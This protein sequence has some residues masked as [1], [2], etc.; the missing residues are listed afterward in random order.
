ALNGTAHNRSELITAQGVYTCREEAASVQNVVSQE[1]KDTAMKLVF[2]RFQREI[3][4]RRVPAVLGSEVVLLNLKFLYGLAGWRKRRASTGLS[5][6]I[7]AVEEKADLI[8]SLAI[9]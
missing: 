9:N 8:R 1:L 5:S 4:R 3:D 6:G 7:H 2:A